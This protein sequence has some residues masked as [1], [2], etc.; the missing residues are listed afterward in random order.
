MSEE[1]PVNERGWSV[2]SGSSCGRND[3]AVQPSPLDQRSVTAWSGLV[4][5]RVPLSGMKSSISGVSAGPSF[6]SQQTQF[7][8]G[9]S[10]YVVTTHSTLSPV[11]GHR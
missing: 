9:E 3:S 7:T 6:V 4:S 1:C 5:R 10:G 11:L 2:V 8:A